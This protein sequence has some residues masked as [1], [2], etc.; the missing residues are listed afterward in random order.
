MSTVTAQSNRII[1]SGSLRHH[2]ALAEIFR[3]N[4]GKHWSSDQLGLYQRSASE[5]SLR[6]AAA[7]EIARMESTV[8]ERTVAEILA[9]YPFE[10]KHQ[11]AR[12]KCVRDISM[13]SVYATA[14]M[15]MN[16]GDW[17]RDRLLLWLRTILQSFYFPK[18]ETAQ[19]KT[20]FGAKSERNPVDDLP[21]RKQSI[22]DTYSTLKRNYQRALVPS[23]FALLEPYL[24]QAIDTLTTD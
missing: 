16:D 23:H 15:L 20:L 6:A 10:E 17:F 18:R 8:V 13:V 14:A 22:Y 24:Q 1:P 12:T 21:Q 7:A 11:Y 19:R 9:S 4:E 5:Y 3:R 2:P